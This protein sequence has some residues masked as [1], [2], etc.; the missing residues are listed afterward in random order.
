MN[1]TY[2]V[3]SLCGD[4]YRDYVDHAKELRH[5]LKLVHLP[6]CFACGYHDGQHSEDC[7]R[8]DW[9]EAEIRAVHGD[10]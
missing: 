2:L 1:E 3:C 6:P 9:T 10:R 4:V 5:K 7:S 8:H